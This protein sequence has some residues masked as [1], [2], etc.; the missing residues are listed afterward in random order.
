MCGEL[1][2]ILAPGGELIG[3]FNIGE[4]ATV[5]E[6]QSLKEADVRHH[7]LRHLDI[8]SY[9]VAKP[10]PQGDAY[11]HFFDDSPSPV[12]TPYYL[13]AR[14]RKPEASCASTAAPPE[15]T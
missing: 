7:L 8:V 12:S 6:P 11:R 9:R 10:G 2:R 15:T 5:E 13:W 4:P 3:S 14:A 1:I